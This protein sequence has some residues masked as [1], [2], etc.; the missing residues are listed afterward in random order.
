MAA[1]RSGLIGLSVA[2]HVMEESNIVI[3]HAPTPRLQAEEET[4]ADWGELTSHGHVTH[5]GAQFMVVTRSGPPG[6]SVVNH[7]EGELS[8]ALV[9]APIPRQRIKDKT[10]GDWGNTKKCE[11]AIHMDVQILVTAC[12]YADRLYL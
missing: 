7:A 9:H 11:Y 10:A 6:L 3:V 12:L 5:L 4:A 2:G 1:T 8:I